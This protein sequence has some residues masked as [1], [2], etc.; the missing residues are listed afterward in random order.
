MTQPLQRRAT[1]PTVYESGV[2]LWIAIMLIVSPVVAAGLGIYL[3][4]DGKHDDAMIL[5]ITAA[6]TLVATAAF[7]VPCRYTILNDALSVRCGII[8]YQ[9]PLEE[10]EKIEPSST[11]RS[12]P[13]LS[14]RRVLVTTSKRKHVL[15]PRK[16]DQFIQDLGDAVAGCNKS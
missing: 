11:L 14:M 7:T 1:R 12:G 10:I 3:L 16:R 15:S 8:F 6:V 5:F 13:A 9:V 4:I 2:D